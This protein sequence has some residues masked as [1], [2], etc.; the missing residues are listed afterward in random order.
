MTCLSLYLSILSLEHPPSTPTVNTLSNSAIPG[1]VVRLCSSAS[2]SRSL[3]LSASS[4][5][6][7]TSCCLYNAPSAPSSSQTHFVYSLRLPV[8]TLCTPFVF[9][10]TRCILTSSSYTHVVYSLRL[11][12][13]TLCTHFVFLYT[14]PIV[15]LYTRYLIT[16]SSV[17]TLCTPCLL[18]TSPSPR[19]AHRSRMPSSA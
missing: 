2:L 8:H 7:A 18:Y 15:F 19:D 9:L 1:Y 11:P 10:C 16:S 4:C 14:T 17:H 6:Y 12:L 13:H 3:H 5:L